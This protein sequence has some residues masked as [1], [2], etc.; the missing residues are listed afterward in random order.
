MK[1]IYNRNLCYI[2]TVFLLIVG[3]C[4]G[5]IQAD[6]C[7]ELDKNGQMIAFLDS[8]EGEVSSYELSAG[9]YI[10]F[11]KASVSAKESR[12]DGQRMITRMLEQLLQAVVIFSF[13][14]V[15]QRISEVQ[16]PGE[17][18]CTDMV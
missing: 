2:V 7:F 14:S 12:M 4:Q 16:V 8:E 13:F 6:F 15:V 9:D 11:R 5:R 10:K 18:S 17:G 3:M 1:W